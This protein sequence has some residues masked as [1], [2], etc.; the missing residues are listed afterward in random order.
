MELNTVLRFPVLMIRTRWTLLARAFQFDTFMSEIGD[1][2][3]NRVP[4]KQ[5]ASKFE[6]VDDDALQALTQH[7][8]IDLTFMCARLGKLIPSTASSVIREKAE[9]IIFRVDLSNENVTHISRFLWSCAS[10][11]IRP[12]IP[13]DAGRRICT[14][15][16]SDKDYCTIVWALAKFA[17]PQH[18]ELLGLF[19]EVTNNLSEDRSRRLSGE[20]ITNLLR[21]ISLVYTR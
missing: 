8:L 18:P 17:S 12:Y 19:T 20:D 4:V 10:L 7:Q 9:D 5:I 1:A 11:G 14:S 6:R 2:I 3:E 13:E 15:D 21:S 16:L